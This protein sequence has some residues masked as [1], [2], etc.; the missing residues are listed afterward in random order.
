MELLQRVR[1]VELAVFL[2]GVAAASGVCCRE[3]WPFFIVQIFLSET[4]IMRIEFKEAEEILV[5]L[6]S[7]SL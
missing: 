4:L 3:L 1:P 6:Q 2:L 5:L 7:S